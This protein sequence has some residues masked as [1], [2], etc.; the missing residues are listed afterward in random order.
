MAVTESSENSFIVVIRV[1]HVYRGFFMSV[2]T[3]W[4]RFHLPNKS[5]DIERRVYSYVWKAK[6]QYK[7]YGG[8]LTGGWKNFFLENFLKEFDICLFDLIS[9]TDDAIILDVKI[10][11][12]VE[13]V[14]PPSQVMRET[15]RG[16]SKR[17]SKFVMD[18]TSEEDV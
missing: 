2:P 14:I 3:E 15:S 9:G 6:Y 5:H 13:E 10:F 11:R 12:V 1:S 17:A 4:A 18:S 16:T 8:G 7:V